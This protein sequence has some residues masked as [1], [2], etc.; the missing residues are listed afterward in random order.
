[1]SKVAHFAVG[2]TKE[3]IFGSVHKAMDCVGWEQAVKGSVFVKVNLLSNQLVPGQ[4]TSPWVLDAVLEKLV[5][6]CKQVYVGDADVATAR[7][8]EQA[9]YRWGHLDVCRKHGVEFINLSKQ[10]EA[11]VT[12]KGRHFKS[13]QVPKI[14]ADVD[15]VVTLPV[16]KTHNVSTMTCSL[17]NQW[18]CLPRF[19]HQFHSRV[20]EVIPEINLAVPVTLVVADATVC[21]EGSGPRT[22]KTKVCN[23]VFASRDRVSL[24]ACIADWMGLGKD[25]VPHISNAEDVG[26]GSMK[27]EVVGD[28]IKPAGFE[29]AVLGKHPIVATEMFLRKIP[30]LRWLL[31]HTP[32][33]KIPAWFAS[34]YNAIW[35]YYKEGVVNRNRLFKDFP[36]YREE[37]GPLVG[38]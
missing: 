11:E 33:F 5:P 2:S 30:G 31:F 32:L 15:C 25:T 24:D 14:L 26:L 34:Q 3:S 13:I 4:C 23:Q 37:F 16:P 27:Y 21:M 8:V 35:Y 18:G 19:R 7:Q 17:K 6:H 22:G 36:M 1:M 20:H 38:R 29:P 10:P 12:I 9:A 28:V